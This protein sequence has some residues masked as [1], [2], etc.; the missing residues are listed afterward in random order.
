MHNHRRKRDEERQ[1]D[2][3]TMADSLEILD[4]FA[5]IIFRGSKQHVLPCCPY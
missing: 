1:E 2:N 5:F 4:F 3:G